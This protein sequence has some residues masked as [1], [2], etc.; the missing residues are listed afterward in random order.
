VKSILSAALANLVF[1]AMLVGAAGTVRYWPAWAYGGTSLTMSVLT[2]VVL[3]RHPDLERERAK[4]GP[5]AKGWDKQLLGLGLLLNVAILVVAGLDAGRFHWAPRL[6][7]VHFV[8]G[9]VLTAAGTALFLLALRENEFFSSVVRIQRDR[10][11]QVCTSGPYR[12]VR[13][14][15]NLGMIIGTVGLP[16]LLMSA[17][18]A[19]PALVFVGLMVVRTHLEDA[20]LT[21]E[22]DGYA[23]Y[24]R[25]TRHRLVPW[26]W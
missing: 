17:W 15:G 1:F 6:G 8:A 22:L 3:R 10:G 12:V 9:L 18:A 26:I 21:K 13:H 20:T 11:H 24:R 16:L 25:A 2:R 23:A 19:I 7:W 14:P 4:P 5:D